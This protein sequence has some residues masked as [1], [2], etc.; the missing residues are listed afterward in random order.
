MDT[1]IGIISVF[2]QTAMP[3]YQQAGWF[4]PHILFLT[5]LEPG[6]SKIRGQQTQRLR[7]VCFLAHGQ[8][9][10]RGVLTWQK[11]LSSPFHVGMNPIPGGSTFM[12]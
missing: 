9:S 1:F 10:S 7:T 5:V 4:K 6:Q 12:T 3:E 8:L 11:E 2:V